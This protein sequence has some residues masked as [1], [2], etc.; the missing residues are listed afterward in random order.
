M[1]GDES[2]VPVGTAQGGAVPLRDRTPLGGTGRAQQPT[3]A[4]AAVGAAIGLVGLVVAGV[5]SSGWELV[6]L[7][8]AV[9]AAVSAAVLLAAAWNERHAAVRAAER[10]RTLFEMAPDGRVVV[11]ERGRVVLVNA[12]AERLFGLVREEL[13]GSALDSLVRPRSGTEQ[14][15]YRGSSPDRVVELD[16]YGRREGVEFPLE[17]SL[18]DMDLAAGRMISLAFKDVTERK[19]AADALAHQ[20]THDPL[21][22][23]PNR[24][25]FLDR[26]EHALA[27]ARRGEARLAVVFLDVDDFKLVNDSRGHDSGDSLLA[28]LT[29]RLSAALRPGDT[30]ARFGGDEFVVVCEDLGCEQ[31]AAAIARRIV[32]SCAQ[33][34]KIGGYEHAVTVSAGVVV[35]DDPRTATPS[36]ILRDADAAM[37]RAK[38]GGN[39][40]VEVF[41]EGM[42][43]RMIERVQTESALH[44][45]LGRGELRLFYQP[46]VSL[47]V[48]E[49]VGAEALLRWQHPRRGLLAPSEFLPVAE[50]SGLIIPIGL[51]V[52][53]EA[54]R[55][56][57]A[58][59]DVRTRREPVPVSV[60]VSSRQIANSDLARS[61]AQVLRGTGLDPSLL[62]VEISEGTLLGDEW[63][64][65]R[66]LRQLK[67]VGVRLVLDDFGSGFCSLNSL[68]R[69]TVD[70]L[71]LDRSFVTALSG[72]D[73]DGAIVNA[74]LGMAEALDLGVTAE[75]VE[76]SQQAVRLR[77]LGCL[78]AQ[79]YLVGRPAPAEQL[80]AL[81]AGKSSIQLPAV[82][83][84]TFNRT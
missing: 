24:T 2:A 19:L 47:A 74:V 79:G 16:L 63:A 40:R 72:A 15:W 26:L 1:L 75:G 55:Q 32:D 38:A 7:I 83:S 71:K 37:Y 18:T 29:A 45:A 56:A 43:A 3:V 48:G 80:T 9:T 17:V 46:V 21:T 41:D 14:P 52:M 27:R 12:K 49:I 78:F 62:D 28:G 73:S 11:D 6:G 36:N 5:L 58:W 84:P 68:R 67:D 57:A 76:T 25:L 65:A 10:F 50:S 59:R 51:W 60:N 22:G 31:D 33:P 44:R 66:A 82:G 61:V 23:L 53:E 13:I 54:C 64:S 8:A 81:L 30:I 70:A 35:V 39:G 20:A 4:L 34:L 69:F 42:R 77:E